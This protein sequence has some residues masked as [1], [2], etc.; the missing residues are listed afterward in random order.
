[1]AYKQELWDEAKKKC[2]IGDEE[3]RMA[4]L[5]LLKTVER[6]QYANLWNGYV[7]CTEAVMSDQFGKRAGE[8]KHNKIIM[9]KLLIL[10][11]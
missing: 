6:V 4:I 5:L 3:I 2:R 8:L 10:Y 7:I 11:N 9:H 1:M